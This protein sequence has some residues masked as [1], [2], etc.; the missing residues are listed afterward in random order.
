MGVPSKIL[1]CT[2]VHL[3]QFFLVRSQQNGNIQGEPTPGPPIVLQ[4]ELA[5]S[6]SETLSRDAFSNLSSEAISGDKSSGSSWVAI[7]GD[8]SSGSSSPVAISRDKSS[9]SSSEAPSP[10]E[11]SDSSLE[12]PSP[13]ESSDSSS[14][15]ALSR[16]KCV[17]QYQ[18]KFGTFCTKFRTEC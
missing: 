9:G 10:N 3:V 18:K 2:L 8:K 13:E 15:E 5:G 17:L 4:V 11:S 1:C 7:S 14:S 6:S 16:E 12:A